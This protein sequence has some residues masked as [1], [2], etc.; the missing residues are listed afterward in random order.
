MLREHKF[1]NYYYHYNN[2]SDHCID[3]D[4]K[5]KAIPCV[6]MAKLEK[7]HTTQRGEKNWEQGETNSK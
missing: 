5:I 3:I 1:I 4:N 6:A 7:K 2:Y